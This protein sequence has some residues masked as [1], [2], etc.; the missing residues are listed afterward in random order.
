LTT[1]SFYYWPRHSTYFNAGDRLDESATPSDSVVDVEAFVE[2]QGSYILS[3]ETD[4]ELTRDRFYKTPF[5]PKPNFYI[6]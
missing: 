2:T 5:W 6:I 1:P 4:L 3:K